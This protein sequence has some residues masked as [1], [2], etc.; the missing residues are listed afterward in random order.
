M[1]AKFSS[2]E[3]FSSMVANIFLFTASAKAISS[4][5]RGLACPY[6]LLVDPV[7]AVALDGSGSK[8]AYGFK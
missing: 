7:P 4:S 5:S 3:I 2:M 6:F 1:R 8:L